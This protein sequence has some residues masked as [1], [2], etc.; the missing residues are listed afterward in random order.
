MKPLTSYKKAKNYKQSLLNSTY[1]NASLPSQYHAKQ[2]HFFVY[3]KLNDTCMLKR[4]TKVLRLL[5]LVVPIF[6]FCTLKTDSQDPIH[7]E[8]L[9]FTLDTIETGIG[10]PWSLA[11]LPDG[12]MLVTDKGGEIRIVREGKLLEGAVEGVP[13]VFTRGQG[14]LFD[15]ELH[16]DYE[17]NGWLYI[18]YAAVADKKGE[19]GGM[20]YIMRARLKDNK[21]VDQQIIFKG[22]PFTNSGVHFGGRM[23]FDKEGYLFFS[24]GERGEM[25]KAQSLETY[26]GKIYRIKDDGSIPVDNPFV[27]TPGAIKAAYTYGN[28]NPQ[29]LAMHPETGEIWETEHGPM[30][31][32]ELNIIRKGKNYGWPE[33]TYGINYDGKIISKDTVKAGMEQ[34][35]I[36]WRPSIATSNLL[37][38][39]SDRYPSWKGNILVCG[40]KLQYVER[41]EIKNDKIVHQ[42]KLLEGIGRVRTVSQ[43]LDG[44]LYVAVEGGKIYK[45]EPVNN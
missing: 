42:E 31:G 3:L 45:I 28:R 4:K 23:E 35:V 18:S 40:M 12:D 26:N 6:S 29:G 7:S 13:K 10:V 36:F 34:P 32:D 19:N 1:P 37:F 9:T 5:I 44:F 21:L 25:K 39:T 2:Q 16:P 24:I 17:N 27:N 20:T 22:E 30:G 11:F 38:V 41:L 14:G 33:I 8:K 15:L 43:G